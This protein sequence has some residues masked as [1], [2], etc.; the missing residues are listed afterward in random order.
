[1]VG[2]SLPQTRLEGAVHGIMVNRKE[3]EGEVRWH[4]LNWTL[5]KWSKELRDCGWAGVMFKSSP[6]SI[7]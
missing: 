4:L 3:D 1:M 7:Q 6:T 2:T 5:S